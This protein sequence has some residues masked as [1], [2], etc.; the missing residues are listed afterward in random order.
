ML[1]T[2]GK[3]LSPVFVFSIALCFL[4]PPYLFAENPCPD[5]D[6]IIMQW[7]QKKVTVEEAEQDN[8]VKDDQ[9]GPDPVPFGFSNDEWRQ[10]LSLKEEGD[11]LWEFRSPPETWDKKHMAGRQGYALIRDCRVIATIITLMN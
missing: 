11:D 2:I 4:V 1:I 6:N 10:L 8:L 5:S 3:P 7:L 9:L